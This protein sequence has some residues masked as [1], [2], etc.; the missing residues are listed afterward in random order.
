VVQQLLQNGLV[1]ASDLPVVQEVL[2]NGVVSASDLPVAQQ[3]LHNGG[4]EDAYASIPSFLRSEAT[5][6]VALTL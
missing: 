3:L 1:P 6:P 4:S 2:Q 5:C